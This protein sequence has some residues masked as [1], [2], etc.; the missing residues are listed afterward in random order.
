MLNNICGDTT[1]ESKSI[2]NTPAVESRSLPFYVLAWGHFYAGKKYFAEREGMD[3][4][5][6]IHTLSG[7]GSITYEGK[8]FTVKEGQSFVLDLSKYHYYRTSPFDAWELIWFRFNGVAA[9]NY[10]E[11]INRNSFEPVNSENPEELYRLFKKIPAILEKNSILND[12]EASMVITNILTMLLMEKNRAY[13]SA[14]SHNKALVDK[15]ANYME[16]NYNKPISVKKIS[17]AFNI[18]EFY[19]SRL[20]N[21]QMGTSPYAYLTRIRISRSKQLLQGTDL[22]VALIAEEVGYQ[23]V[24]NYIRNFKI[25]TGT[26]PL[27][28][29]KDKV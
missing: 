28:F 20:F 7:A 5:I 17:E 13:K 8:S 22:S 15:I 9:R 25:L 21:K 18:N 16:M 3:D 12:A 27:K 24:M 1:K 19:L 10:V 14:V 29:R 11:L 6:V 23:D 4:L 2:L 26:T